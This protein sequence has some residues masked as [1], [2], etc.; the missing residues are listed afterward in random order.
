MRQIDISCYQKVGKAM[1]FKNLNIDRSKIDK[2]IQKWAD[3]DALPEPI[4]KGGAYHYRIQKD[5]VE[6]LLVMYYKKDGTTT[7]DPTV[8]KNREL[9][10]QL[11]EYIKVN[12]LIT[13]RK[14]FSLSFRDVAEEDFS[15][16]LE[17][18]QQDLGATIIEDDHKGA[19]RVLKI[20]GPFGDEIVVTHY[21]NRTVLVQGKPLNLYVEV[22][23][24]FYEILSF[25]QVVKYEAETYEINLDVNDVRHE[26]GAYLPTAFSF[27]NEKMVKII[28]PSL[29][30][31]K[32]EIPLEDYSSFVF[33]VLRGLEGYIRQL[34]Q[35]KSK[36]N[37]VKFVGPLSKLFKDEDPNKYCCLQDF[38]K[39]DIG[40]DQT[41]EAIEKTYNYWKSKRHPFFH[42]DKRINMT[43]I[44]Y[45]KKTAEALVHDTLILIEDTYSKII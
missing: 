40:C 32:L 33:P 1:T 10:K 7:I 38:A 36:E 23:L 41:C 22:K 19:G 29:S 6:A 5:N 20:K 15:L 14:N 42:V 21:E 18:L 12:C 28:T 31:M 13:A 2:T 16:L 25:E 3:L 24:F 27:L 45:D 34:L 39:S 8:G 4:K 30:L 11:A 9:S 35:S 37:F 17:F 26:L 43:P 44:I